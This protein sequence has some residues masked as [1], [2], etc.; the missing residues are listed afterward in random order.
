MINILKRVGEEIFPQF[1]M[2]SID[3]PNRFR[4]T[5]YPF[6]VAQDLQPFDVASAFAAGYGGTSRVFN[7]FNDLEPADF[8]KKLTP[9]CH[10]MRIP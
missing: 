3:V 7:N 8:S 4:V 5:L 10:R 6:D 2:Y 9:K 1:H